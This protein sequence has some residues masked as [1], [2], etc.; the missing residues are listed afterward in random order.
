MR[1][2]APALCALVLTAAA[3]LAEDGAR[4]PV[5]VTVEDTFDNAAF[6]VESAIVGAGLVVDH[7]SHTGD[8]LERTKGAVGATRTLY[9][10]ADIY[11]FCSAKVSREAMEA[12][13][14]NVQYCPYAI[15][16]YERPEAPGTIVI[17]HAQYP[18][19]S[20]APVNEMLDA[21]LADAAG[22]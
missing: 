4:P 7:V 5:T 16:V 21:I 8:M 19:A 6:A 18:G 15:F 3:A 14:E 20:M 12:N 9:T 1:S 17:G 10:H 11:S 13:I 2:L 22:S